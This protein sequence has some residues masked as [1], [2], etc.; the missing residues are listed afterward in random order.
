MM[1][2]VHGALTIITVF[3]VQCSLSAVCFAQPITSN[4]LI[5]KAKDYDGKTVAYEGEVI[6]DI[7][8]RK[9]FVWINVN[10][11]EN[12][13]GIWSNAALVK[14]I[15]YTGS[16]K[17]A[18]DRIEVT[19]V[20]HQ[21]CIEHGGDLDIH[22][23]ALRKTR[24]GRIIKEKLNPQKMELVILLLGILGLTWISSLLKRK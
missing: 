20:F 9:D 13:I 16:Y 17:S 2:K 12:A 19:G 1:N 18:G 3:I 10:D 21:A 23:S 6:G 24:A 5:N 11:G 7:M 8:K 14:D 4:E 22:A 15:V